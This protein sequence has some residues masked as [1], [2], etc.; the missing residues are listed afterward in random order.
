[1]A[2]TCLAAAASLRR[3]AGVTTA[4]EPTLVVSVVGAA[5]LLLNL[6]RPARPE[7][8]IASEEDLKKTRAAIARS[9]QSLA[10]AALMGDKRLLFS[11]DAGAFL[12]YQ[13][14]GRS[15]IAL[16]DPVG[17]DRQSD[18]LVWR[19]R[20]LS[21]RHGGWTVFYQA[22]PTR[23]PQYIDLGLA[24]FK[25]GEEAHVPLADFSLEG[26][27]RAELRQDHRRAVRDGATFELVPAAQ[28]P[29]LLPELRVISNAWLIS[30]TSTSRSCAGWA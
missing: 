9:E 8:V 4:C 11:D 22:T 23:L 27:A 21:D 24:A 1:M 29:R 12:M 15:W 16:G 17:D 19:F 20:E 26:G 14:S 13:V 7:P 28:V 3:L 18:E 5:F 25:L 2:N 30:A 6:L 10:N